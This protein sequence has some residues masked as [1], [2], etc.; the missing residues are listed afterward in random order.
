MFK[1]ILL[2]LLAVMNAYFIFTLTTAHSIN[3]LSIHIIAAGF[4]FILSVL[5]LLTRVP[6]LTRI[7]SS[8]TLIIAVYHIAL[9]VMAIYHYVY[10][11]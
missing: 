9:I 3:L 7:L 10:A 8:V 6:K 11:K 2:L 4:A 5:Y 1:N